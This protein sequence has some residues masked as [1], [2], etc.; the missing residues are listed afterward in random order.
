MVCLQTE[1][2]QARKKNKIMQIN[3]Q[4]NHCLPTNIISNSLLT[5]KAYFLTVSWLG[6]YPI[7]TLIKSG[8]FDN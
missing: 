2:I 4:N 7:G 1:V 6:L 5:K 8:L 3:F